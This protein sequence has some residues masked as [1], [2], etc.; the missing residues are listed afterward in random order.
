[1]DNP[2]KSAI[3]IVAMTANAFDEDRQKAADAG[4]DGHVA[5]PIDTDKLCQEIRRVIKG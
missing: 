2:A 3:P 5:K 1:M 4:M